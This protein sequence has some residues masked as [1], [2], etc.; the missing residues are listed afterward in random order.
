MRARPSAAMR[1][2]AGTRAVSDAGGL[3]S[4]GRPERVNGI[5]TAGSPLPA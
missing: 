4:M 1:P 5:I 2:S 3:A